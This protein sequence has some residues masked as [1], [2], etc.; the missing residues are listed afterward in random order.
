[1]QPIHG[2]T[3]ICAVI[4][5]PIGHTLSPCMHN[6]A[7]AACNLNYAYVAFHVRDVAKAAAGMVGFNIRGLSVT[8][9]HKVEIMK[10]LDEI[11]PLA[12]NIGAVNTIINR[13][14]RLFG[15][16]TDGYG[17]LKSLEA[18]ENLD[19]KT[20]VILGAGGATQAIAFTIASERNPRRLLFAVRDDDRPAA[21]KL[22]AA[23]SDQFATPVA[24]TSIEWNA[25]REAF[26]DADVI[27]NTTPIGMAP[28]VE[29]C[30]VPEDALNERH[31]VFDIIYNPAK[32][33][34]LQRA[35]KRSARIINGVPMFVHQGAE[36]FRL[37]TGIEP[38]IAVMQ[39][40]VENALRK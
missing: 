4:G 8:I 39:A 9:P 35:E 15:T 36:Q 20:I 7:F 22:S 28:N 33:L 5:D 6:A 25:L 13:D 17:A 12:G 30:L 27:I 38:P 23:I 19:Q 16:N 37:W 18:F 40:A 11:S 24:I 3:T 1:M 2:S 21:E 26:A 14:G 32:T 34:L 10:Y 31:L 29:E